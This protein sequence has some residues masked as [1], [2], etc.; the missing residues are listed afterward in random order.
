[1][2][3]WVKKIVSNL[4][5]FSASCSRHCLQSEED[6]G[7]LFNHGRRPSALQP[8]ELVLHRKQFREKGVSAALSLKNE[9]VFEVVSQPSTTTATVQRIEAGRP[10]AKHTFPLSNLA[11]L[12]QRE[13]A[14]LCAD[15]P[16]EQSSDLGCPQATGGRAG[17]KG[18]GRLGPALGAGRLWSALACGP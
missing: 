3:E 9:G 18:R 4:R 12:P 15:P 7:R 11:C 17:R 16:K 10:T 8:G 13:R 5:R 2:N 14:R 1:M 6:Y